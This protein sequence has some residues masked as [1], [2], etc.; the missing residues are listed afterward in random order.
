MKSDSI[1]MR[2]AARLSKPGRLRRTWGQLVDLLADANNS[3]PIS[4]A[5]ADKVIGTGMA[6]LIFLVVS[7]FG[8]FDKVSGGHV[9]SWELVSAN[10]ATATA[11]AF[12]T[13]YLFVQP[14]LADR[15]EERKRARA[16]DAEAASKR[17][18]A[19]YDPDALTLG[20]AELETELLGG[21]SRYAAILA[22]VNGQNTE[23]RALRDRLDL[24]LRDNG[25]EFLRKA[26][27]DMDR[28]V[29]RSSETQERLAVYH[30]KVTAFLTECRDTVSRIEPSLRDLE[31]VREVGRLSMAAPELEREATAVID[32]GVARLR[33]RMAGVRS[34]VED[35][36]GE[37]QIPMSE[38]F[39]YNPEPAREHDGFRALAELESRIETFD[40]GSLRE[41]A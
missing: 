11:L 31:L 21:G 29:T 36:F 18:C 39:A 9:F 1:V 33:A 34:E 20:I 17:I 5:H 30:A 28:L 27:D 7:L 4:P 12:L 13:M 26:R 14:T 35:R 24:R 40:P 6:S 10:F 19:G 8:L 23:A 25:A 38:L 37:R 3:G 16:L 41:I 32:D 15:L 22:R 2:P